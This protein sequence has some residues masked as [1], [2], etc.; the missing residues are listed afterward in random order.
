MADEGT[1]YLN[2]NDT[3]P[4]SAADAFTLIGADG[5]VQQLPPGTVVKMSMWPRSSAVP[6]IDERACTIIDV[7]GKVVPIP[8][9]SDTATP[10]FFFAKFKATLPDG[11]KKTFPNEGLGFPIVISK[12]E[13]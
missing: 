6:T 2:Q 3:W 13:V 1:F 5:V 8:Q 11:Q 4:T 12:N 10:G 9:A 7:N